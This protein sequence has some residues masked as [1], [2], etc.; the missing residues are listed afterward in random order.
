MTWLPRILITYVDS[1]GNYYE[2]STALFVDKKY[3]D[4]QIALLQSQIDELKTPTDNTPTIHTEIELN[5]KGDLVCSWYRDASTGGNYTK[6]NDGW[7]VVGCCNGTSGGVANTYF[8]LIG[9]TQQSCAMSASGTQS[10]TIQYNGET[11]YYQVKQ[12]STSFVTDYGKAVQLEETFTDN[13][14]LAT[15]VLDY[16]SGTA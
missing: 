11:Y 16:Y 5:N 13:N 12:V 4:E 10:G 15:K 2:D 7:S 6:S 9:K 3:V 1:D 14:T 8:A